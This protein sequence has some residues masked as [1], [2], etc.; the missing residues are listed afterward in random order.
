[1]SDLLSAAIVIIFDGTDGQ[2]Y[3]LSLDVQQAALANVFPHSADSANKTIQY[4]IF[5][6]LLV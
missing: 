3:L 1:M 5:E 6:L 2:S 4:S